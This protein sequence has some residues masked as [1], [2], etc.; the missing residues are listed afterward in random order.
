MDEDIFEAIL[1]SSGGDYIS[2]AHLLAIMYTWQVN[3][4]TYQ[5]GCQMPTKPQKALIGLFSVD[6]YGKTEFS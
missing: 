1:S 4:K 5:K 3:G 6:K 2:K